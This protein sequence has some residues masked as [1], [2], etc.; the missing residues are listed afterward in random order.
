MFNKS[1]LFSFLAIF[2]VGTGSA[3][4]PTITVSVSS[5][6]FN[7]AIRGPK[8]I[9][10]VRVTSSVPGSFNV[11]FTNP[12][13]LS[14]PQGDFTTPATLTIMVDPGEFGEPTLSGMLSF[15]GFGSL[16]GASATAPVTLNRGTVG[17][18][19]GAPV[20]GGPITRTCQSGPTNCIIPI[21]LYNGTGT[22][23]ITFSLHSGSLPRGM[24]LDG[25]SSAIRAFPT[26]SGVYTFRLNATDS[27]HNSVVSDPFT[28]TVLETIDS[29]PQSFVTTSLPNGTN[30]TPYS[31]T[32]LSTG[33]NPPYFYSVPGGSLPR[34]LTLS[35]GGVISGTPF[36]EGVYPLSITSVD[37][38]LPGHFVSRTFTLNILPC[39]T[40]QPLVIST[41]AQV[42]LVDCATANLQ[43]AAT[44][45]IGPY[46]WSVAAN[47]ALPANLT[48]TPSGLLAGSPIAPGI[49]T[50]N[51]SVKDSTSSQ[52][53]TTKTFTLDVTNCQQT[54][55]LAITTVSPLPA[56]SVCSNTPIQLLATGG[57]QP[58][59]SWSIT[60]GALPRPMTLSQAGL[61]SGIPYHSGVYNFFAQVQDLASAR[62]TRPFTLTVN[63]CG[64]S[65]AVEP[66]EGSLSISPEGIPRFQLAKP[67]ESDMDGTLEIFP[68]NAEGEF[69][70]FANALRQISFNIKAGSSDAIFPKQTGRLVMLST[71]G[72]ATVVPTLYRKG[73]PVSPAS[74]TITIRDNGT[75]E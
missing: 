5:I 38:F 54:P 49:Y 52:T 67:A 7:A 56:Q 36:H 22:G 25:A 57:I 11:N 73:N 3:Q 58:V 27:L 30:C 12:S 74:N 31:A 28:I 6:V 2:C 40:L 35:S 42:P 43:L 21:I 20:W 23:S 9:Q 4:T 50:F 72:A 63:A 45:G 14:P 60:N 1:L 13:W 26:G 69:A 44:G 24:F 68:A 65:E 64:A 32:I 39:G 37:S 16:A 62:V 18:G 59:Y 17:G 51:I 41:P 47:S 75:V 55:P 48:L 10:A 46:T 29:G 15:V 8:L 71:G 70:Y 34:P 61:I 53:T 66:L 33:G 19:S